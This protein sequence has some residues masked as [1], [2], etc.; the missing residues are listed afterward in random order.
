MNI[1]MANK[2]GWGGGGVGGLL[3]VRYLIS[4]RKDQHHQGSN[5]NIVIVV[6]ATIE[7]EGKPKEEGKLWW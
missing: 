3:H 4:R 1:T 7:K 2:V 6:D 5:K